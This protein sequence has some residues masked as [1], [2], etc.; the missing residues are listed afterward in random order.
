MYPENAP[1]P[2]TAKDGGVEMKRGLAKLRIKPSALRKGEQRYRKSLS[3]PAYYSQL[4]K[5][6]FRSYLERLTDEV[7]EE[8]RL[9]TGQLTKKGRPK[10]HSGVF[11]EEEPGFL[12]LAALDH[13]FRTVGGSLADTEKGPWPSVQRVARAIAE[14]VERSRALRV[15][16]ATDVKERKKLARGLK[17]KYRKSR[18]RANVRLRIRCRERW[19]L[20]H[21][22]KKTCFYAA[23]VLIG[24]ARKTRIIELFNHRELTCRGPRT[25]KLVRFSEDVLQMLRSRWKHL[26]PVYGPMFS[27]PMRWKTLEDGGYRDVD[28]DMVKHWDNPAILEALEAA[29]LREVRA[30]INALQETPWQ[31]N[32]DV[33]RVM[34]SQFRDENYLAGLAEDPKNQRQR[35]K[36][37]HY[38]EHVIPARLQLAS[39]LIGKRF[40]FPYQIDFRGRAYAVPQVFNPQS[41]DMGRALLRFATGKALGEKGA[42]WLAIYLANMWGLD[43]VDKGP[44]QDRRDWVANNSELI[45]A[46]ASMETRTWMKAEEPWRFL[47]AC[48]EWKGYLQS[49]SAFLSHLPIA[50]DG[51]CNG[52]QHLSAIA[53]DPIVAEATNL[54]FSNEPRDIYLT[55]A[56]RLKSELLRRTANGDSNAKRWLK[57]AGR[58]MVKGATMTKPYGVKL[59][60]I[61][62]QLLED[63]FVTGRKEA[64]ELAKVIS[65][66]I[67]NQIEQPVIIMR[68]LS[69][70]ARQLAQRNRRI[71][72]MTPLRFPVVQ[73]RHKKWTLYIQTA[74]G[75]MRLNDR[76][77]SLPLDREAQANAIVAN[78]VQSLDAAHMMATVNNLRKKDLRHFEMVHD[79]YAVHACDVEAM[80]DALREEFVR[81]YQN[82]VLK[83][84]LERQRSANPDIDLPDPP[85]LGTLDIN[86]VLTSPYFFS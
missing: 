63:G 9:L 71:E 61:G 62:D 54:I 5:S 7:E 15:L 74:I 43:G 17:S 65:S 38:L 12:A 50:M 21:V 69:K 58:K 49:G 79:S 68:W 77:P 27:K 29:D 1:L 8:R 26:P 22:E 53:R 76:D 20:D 41:D 31:I 84:F 13:V 32:E 78:L 36:R 23:G 56:D 66:C 64:S 34:E 35:E 86:V 24:L 37:D 44:F 30:A 25:P 42:G 75:K 52:L 46:A 51:T 85:A 45:L 4:G 11:L 18:Q 73:E 80:N 3:A 59:N 6:F 33:Y 60:G 28:L 81:L 70:V 57:D 40:Y 39:D 55:V 67:D 82:D 19:K 48:F 72:W 14:E 47:A 2:A 10:V 16:Q 83:D